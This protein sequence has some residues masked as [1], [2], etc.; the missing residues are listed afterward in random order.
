MKRRLSMLL[1]L[2]FAFILTLM[3][4]GLLE[5]NQYQRQLIKSERE[6]S[7]WEQSASNF[8]QLFGS[9]WSYE[10]QLQRRMHAM[11]QRIRQWEGAYSAESF[12]SD[13]QE[14][15]PG[16]QYPEYTYAGVYDRQV[17]KLTMFSGDS[18]T[19]S[20]QRF[21]Q[22]LL[23][24]LAR[25]EEL[26]ANEK[27]SLDSFIRGAFGENLDFNLLSNFRRGKIVRAVFEGSLK[28]VYWEKLPLPGKEDKEL[29]HIQVFHPRALTRLESMLQ[30]AAALGDDGINLGAV[31]VPL[32]YADP[33]LKPVFA[34]SVTDADRREITMALLDASKKQLGREK[35]FPFGEAFE[36]GK[37]RILRDFIDY[38]V[39]YELWVVG[40]NEQS[41]NTNDSIAGFVFRLFFFSAWFLV[42]IRVLITGRPIGISLKA[43]LSLIFLVVGILPLIVFYVAGIFHIDASAYRKEQEAVKD[44]LKQMED[45]D[46]SGEALLAEYRDFC[47][48]L[49][50][51]PEWL[52]LIGSWD[53]EMWE[54]AWKT[55]PSRTDPVGLKIEAMYVF[56]PDVASLTSRLFFDESSGISLERETRIQNFYKDWI[57]KAYFEIVPEVMS[58]KSP[59]LMV[60]KG[61]SSVEMMRYLL[62]NRGDI[63]FLDL[64][65]DK[66]FMY[67]NYVLK[68]GKPHNW[69]FFR[70][71]IL[72]KF[73][74]YLRASVAN[75]QAVFKDNIYSIA[76]LEDSSSKIIFPQH[77]GNQQQIIKRIAARGIDLAAI[78]R[79]KIIEQMEDYLV[80]AYPCVKSGPFVLSSIVLL[81]GFRQAAAV[82]ELLLSII[83]VLMSIPVFIV[84][85][86]AADYLVSPLVGVEKGLKK[87]A[88]GD[89]SQRFHLKRDDELGMLT[90]AF[91][92]MTEGLKERINLG[93]FVSASLD[94]QV[95]NHDRIVGSG[96]QKS[97]GAILCCDIRAFTSLS[98]RYNV[99][100]IVEMLNQHL[101]AMSGRIQKNN[102]FIEQFVGDAV[103][104]VFYGKN[105][106]ECVKTALNAAIDLTEEHRN[107]CNNREQA[108]LFKYE[109]GVGID[110]GIIISGII[111]VG[112]RR[113]FS[114]VGSIR[115][116]AEKLEAMTKKCQVFKI[117][118]S[119]NVTDL[120]G[121]AGFSQIL[122]EE[123]Y[124]LIKLERFT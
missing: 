40:K 51:D 87:I 54:R 118:V 59:D 121:L 14:F 29:V 42:M 105:R 5:Y 17:S 112:N 39:P 91:D 73:E 62:S 13:L 72:K 25:G 85:R 108:G 55:M 117:A 83:V 4:F 110:A 120:V 113:E 36:L 3:P 65:A 94:E 56:P 63:E 7:H 76:V 30:A 47:Q 82:Q 31:F 43:W 67:Q 102:G 77:S 124:E 106:E 64:E 32:E 50:R 115:N 28:L 23:E 9:L 122:N 71:D 90:S 61:R 98:E 74:R 35:I 2:V 10:S 45:A 119:T 88:E 101:A 104:A 109:I 1:P 19:R 79:T 53:E 80:I 68:D 37:T 18:F 8:V 107:I 111:N 26:S 69:Y 44:A 93:R 86:F 116:Q 6:K 97:F 34:S 66:Q 52:N 33:L 48:K 21:Y 16:R 60:F 46:S 38:S 100:E 96:M 15:L 103:L 92:R 24:G 95:G 22:R 58:G 49:D 123:G 20:K 89:F 81:R 11:H 75:L 57:R 12:I 78:S 84:A 99:R 27:K 41:R 114:V 70:V